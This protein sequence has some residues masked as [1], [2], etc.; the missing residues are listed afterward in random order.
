MEDDQQRSK[1][2]PRWWWKRPFH[3]LLLVGTTAATAST[4]STL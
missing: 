2:T 3:D 4:M 1:S